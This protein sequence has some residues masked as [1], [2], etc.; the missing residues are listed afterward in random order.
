M[1]DMP[2]AFAVSRMQIKFDLTVCGLCTVDCVLRTV[3]AWVNPAGYTVSGAHSEIFIAPRTV[4]QHHRQYQD[5]N[6]S[7]HCLLM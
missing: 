6:Q 4:R 3:A 1:Y 5:D 2:G 7:L